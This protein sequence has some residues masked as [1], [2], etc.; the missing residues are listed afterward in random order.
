[1][2][3]RRQD[4]VRARDVVAEGGPAVR[5]DEDRSGVMDGSRAPRRGRPT[6]SWRCSG[7]YAF[8]KASAVSS[9]SASINDDAALGRKLSGRSAASTSGSG[10]T[11]TDWAIPGRARPGPAGPS[12]SCVGRRGGVG[13]DDELARAGQRLDPDLAEQAPLGLLDVRVPRPDD[14]VDRGDRRRSERRAPP[15]P[16]PRRPRRP[17]PRREGRRR[18]ARRSAE[19]PT[20]LAASR[21]RSRAHP[22]PAPARSPSRRSTDRRRR[23]PGT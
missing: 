12:A 4:V 14:H 10:D 22:R 17:P 1:M 9:E 2:A 15:P 21:R 23:P 13:H 3:A 6:I 7:A 19:A 11:S 5:A 8:T 16:A 18:R 20:A